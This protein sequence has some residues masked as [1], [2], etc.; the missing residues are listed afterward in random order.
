MIIELINGTIIRTDEDLFLYENLK[1][2]HVKGVTLGGNRV[3][4]QIP[5]SS[6][7]VVYKVTKEAPF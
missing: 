5:S 2:V 6:I 3:D 4:A 7:A 1:V